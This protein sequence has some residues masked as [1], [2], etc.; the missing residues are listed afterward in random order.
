MV[1]VS[2]LSPSYS[3]LHL[4]YCK[5]HIADSP[6]PPTRREVREYWTGSVEVRDIFQDPSSDSLHDLTRPVPQFPS[7]G[8][9]GSNIQHTQDVK[10]N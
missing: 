3:I 2:S 10:F 6:S 4:P 7:P 9:A 5:A 8:N 1:L